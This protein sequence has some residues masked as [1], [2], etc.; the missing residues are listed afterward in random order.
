M[1]I[2]PSRLG[3]FVLENWSGDDALLRTLRRAGLVSRNAP[4]EEVTAVFRQAREEHAAIPE[5]ARAFNSPHERVRVFL[6][7]FLTARGRAW[8]V[9]LKS[10]ERPWWRFWR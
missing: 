9:P 2:A 4:D 10:L 1:A 7:P 5:G 3:K 6:E 8:A